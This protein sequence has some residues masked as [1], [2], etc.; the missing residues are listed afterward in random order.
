MEG[1]RENSSVFLLNRYA[2]FISEEKKASQSSLEMI[3][4]VSRYVA[5][6]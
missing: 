3:S 2:A 6:S 5:S 4:L 1:L